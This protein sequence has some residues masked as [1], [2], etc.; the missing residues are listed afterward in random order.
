MAPHNLLPCSSAD[1]HPRETRGL[2]VS[3]AHFVLEVAL[4]TSA[5]NDNISHALRDSGHGP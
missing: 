4:D 2:L 5:H 1:T 3:M